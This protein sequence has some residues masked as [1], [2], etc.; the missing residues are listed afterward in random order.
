MSKERAEPP[1]SLLL[2]CVLFTVLESKAGLELKILLPHP[3]KS[4]PDIRVLYSDTAVS[5]PQPRRQVKEL[6][7]PVGMNS[8]FIFDSVCV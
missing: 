5:S 7:V 2:V 4:L 1:M 3:F 6:E 8:V